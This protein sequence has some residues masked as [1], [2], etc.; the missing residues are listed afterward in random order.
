MSSTSLPG[1]TRILIADDDPIV[2]DV[3]MRYLSAD[4]FDVTE[5]AD[6]AAAI[7]AFE[8]NPHDL[9]VIDLMMPR[10]DGFGVLDRVRAH[11][12][13]AAVIMLTARGSESDRVVGLELGAD[14]Y[15][16]KPFSPREMVAR[17]RAVL[18]RRVSQP[19]DR[20]GPPR[21]IRLADL[22]ID[23]SAREVLLR[24][25]QVALTPREFELLQFF[26]ENPRVA[27]TRSRLLDEI[28]DLAYDGDPSTVTVHIR[29]LR[30][31]I[32]DDP[33][34]PRRLRTVWGAGYRFDP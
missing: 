13:Q 12:E 28:W 1:D 15:V 9:I 16:A 20:G 18:R 2:R 21:T 31:K 32:E 25:R 29:R 17:C 22:S 10:I 14:D 34:N 4:G 3:L 5:A 26:A 30:E 24:G 19:T 11:S 7:E 8:R 27:F 33:S 23:P 6:G